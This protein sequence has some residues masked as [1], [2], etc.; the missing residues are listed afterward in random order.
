MPAIFTHINIPYS[1]DVGP[2]PEK[3]KVIIV[4]GIVYIIFPRYNFSTSETFNL[5]AK[6]ALHFRRNQSIVTCLLKLF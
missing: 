4:E 3:T 2:L 5:I 1:Q 6:F